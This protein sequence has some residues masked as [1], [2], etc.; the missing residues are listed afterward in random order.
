MLKHRVRAEPPVLG[1]H[2]DLLSGARHRLVDVRNVHVWRDKPRFTVGP[3][4]ERK[5]P[6][7][8]AVGQAN[9]QLPLRAAHMSTHARPHSGHHLHCGTWQHLRQQEG[10]GEQSQVVPADQPGARTFQSW[11]RP[12]RRSRRLL[13][14]RWPRS[15]RSRNSLL[16]SGSSFRWADGCLN[17]RTR[18]TQR[19]R[20]LSSA[21]P[22][23]PGPVTQD[24]PDEVLGVVTDLLSAAC[25]IP[26]RPLSQLGSLTLRSLLAR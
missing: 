1:E 3:L 10:V 15:Q 26:G 8:P 20:A 22:W 16:R 5:R 24:A 2:H 7:A 19:R 9:A 4:P 18:R 11:C 23:W 21:T 6:G 14:P 12:R 13:P 25:W 17:R